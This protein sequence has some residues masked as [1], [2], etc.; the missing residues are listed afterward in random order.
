MRPARPLANIASRRLLVFPVD[1]ALLDCL[2]PRRCE[3]ISVGVPRAR[4]VL[5]RALAR[6]RVPVRVVELPASSVC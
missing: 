2:R 3:R 6:I 5:I 4:R 1:G